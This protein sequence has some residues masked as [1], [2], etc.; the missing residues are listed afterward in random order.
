MEFSERLHELR[1]EAEITQNRLASETGVTP[2][3]RISY[4]ENHKTEPHIKELVNFARFFDC[5]LDFL[6]GVTDDRGRAP[7]S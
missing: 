6:I 2:E 3:N 4:L 7:R 5:S 1:Q